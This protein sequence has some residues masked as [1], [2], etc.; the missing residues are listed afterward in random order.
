M[1]LIPGQIIYDR[2]RVIT[3]LSPGG[4]SAVYEVID[5]T[6]S[7]RCALK[8]MM[9][10]PGTSTTALPQLREQFQQEARL[11]AEL[12]HPSLPRVT[13]H[14]EEDGNVYLVMD[15]IYG[16]R[17]DQVIAQD[18]DLSE[19]RVLDW[20]RQ[21]MEALA[22]CHKQ[23]VIHR[24]VKPQNVIITS[25]DRAVLVDFGLAKLMD[26]SNPRT[27]TVMQ[28]LGTP[29]YAPPEQYDTKDGRRTDSR[30]DIYSLGA[31]LYHALAGKPPPMLAERVMDP[32][33]LVPMREL[34]K[35]TSLAINQVIM[36]AME[37]QPVERF[38]NIVEMHEALFGPTQPRLEAQNV[39]SAQ[40][41]TTPAAEPSRSTVQLSQV[42][43]DR[44]E[45]SSPFRNI[46]ITIGLAA[47]VMVISLMAGGTNL[48][49]TFITTATPTPSV[50]MTPTHPLPTPS[51]TATLTLTASPT[52]RATTRR[53]TRTPEKT[54]ILPSATP[55][56]SPTP[57]QIYIPPS[58]TPSPTSTPTNTPQPPQPRRPSRTPTPTPIT[59]TPT[60]ITPTSTPITPTPSPT[61]TP[62]PIPGPTTTTPTP[63]ESSP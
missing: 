50:T 39:T 28:G 32:A 43:T 40:V 24:D 60:P 47:L 63:S 55:T 57:T 4:M 6:L 21:L 61:D 42:E 59:P 44:L 13:D 30:T 8:E 16:K 38:Q 53:P 23:G 34:R 27:R 18:G 45:T 35:D 62:R 37:L 22:Y 3:L 7:L 31:T 41:D 36:K 14:F 20:A 12:R 19:E 9:P 11:L 54:D 26:P 51:P 52:A 10:Y 46:L 56:P 17:L 5:I 58:P 2:Y 1:S 48:L 29:E 15:Y 49:N 25:R 33:S